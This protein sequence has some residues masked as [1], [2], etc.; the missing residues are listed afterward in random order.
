MISG[1]SSKDLE[2]VLLNTGVAVIRVTVAV[3][4]YS[5]GNVR[6]SWVDWTSG[7]GFKADASAPE[8]EVAV[9]NSSFSGSVVGSTRKAGCETVQAATKC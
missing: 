5:G 3:G 4:E 2:R 9:W 8:V 7:E 1:S 6:I